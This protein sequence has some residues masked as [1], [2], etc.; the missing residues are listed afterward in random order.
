LAVPAPTRLGAAGLDVGTDA[1]VGSSVFFTQAAA[2]TAPPV[3][4]WRNTIG[5]T[6][7]T[8]VSGAEI[9]GTSNAVLLEAFAADRLFYFAKDSTGV[10]RLWTT[11]GA[12]AAT[13]LSA[14]SASGNPPIS[15][16]TSAD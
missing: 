12:S 2:A 8:Q 3:T 5:H 7:E 15:Y 14:A 9:T 1:L 16:K 6:G 10:A 11:D 4:V 13:A